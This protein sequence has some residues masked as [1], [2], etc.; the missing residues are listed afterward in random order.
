[1]RGKATFILERLVPRCCNAAQV[2][3]ARIELTAAAASAATERYNAA[4]A[5][6]GDEARERGEAQKADAAAQA[7]APED[8]AEEGDGS[9]APAIDVEAVRGCWERWLGVQTQ[10]KGSGV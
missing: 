1:V 8:G 10:Y 9:A 5:K 3:T 2:G 7:A 4:V 6:A